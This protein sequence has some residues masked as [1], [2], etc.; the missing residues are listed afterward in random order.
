MTFVEF[1]IPEAAVC[2]LVLQDWSEEA[3]GV[4]A[5]E[6][7]CESSR[8]EHHG[9]GGFVELGGD[10]AFGAEE[11]VHPCVVCLGEEQREVAVDEVGPA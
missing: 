3:E 10:E 11:R 9:G 6:L 5:N 7:L 1:A 2:H 4:A 8:R